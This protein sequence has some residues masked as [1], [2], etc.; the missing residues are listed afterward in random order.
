[1]FASS[2]LIG[3]VLRGL[4]GL[5]AIVTAI[6]IGRQPGAVALILSLSL[7]LISLVALRGCPVCWT[8]GLIETIRARRLR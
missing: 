7:A 4:I 6:L 1:M 5:G 3:H 8:I 2:T